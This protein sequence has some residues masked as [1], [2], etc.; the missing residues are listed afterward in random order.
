M[1]KLR[2][3]KMEQLVYGLA[4]YKWQ[5]W[6]SRTSRLAP[7]YYISQSPFLKEKT[8]KQQCVDF[9]QKLFLYFVHS[10][11]KTFMSTYYVL[12]TIAGSVRIAVNKNNKT[13]TQGT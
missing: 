12:E 13:W 2:Q 5:T 1:R 4:T 10:V 7:K 6:D 11:K 9:K 8:G 3:K